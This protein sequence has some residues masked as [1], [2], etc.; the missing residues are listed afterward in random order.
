MSAKAVEQVKA[1]TAE[2][3]RVFVASGLSSYLTQITLVGQV[4]YPG[5]SVLFAAVTAALPVAIRAVNPKDAEFG[6]GY[7]PSW[8]ATVADNDD[9]AGEV[10]GGE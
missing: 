1:A 6:R 8:Q 2:F 5:K 7:V 4:E 9:V 10:E 3:A